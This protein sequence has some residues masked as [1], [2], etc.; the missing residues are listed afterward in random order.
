MNM[1]KNARLTPLGRERLVRLMQC[2]HTPESALRLAGV[3]PRTAQKWLRRY[4]QEGLPGLQDRS[5]R[6]SCRLSSCM[7]ANL[8]P[9]APWQSLFRRLRQL[10][11]IPQGRFTRMP[12]SRRSA[13]VPSRPR[14]SASCDTMI[15]AWGRPCR[16]SINRASFFS[17]R[18]LVGSSR[19]RTSGAIAST[20][21]RL[22][23]RFSP[24][25]S[26]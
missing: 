24:P 21:A 20:V 6:P 13:R 4:E 5:S 2:G 3:C 15:M 17:S 8:A 19:S 11:A 1:H 9:M 12:S 18:A 25:E 26:L 10:R 23:S 22:T 16:I 14:K 7:L